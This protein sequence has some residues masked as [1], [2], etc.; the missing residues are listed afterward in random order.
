LVENFGILRHLTPHEFAECAADVATQPDGVSDVPENKMQ[1]LVARIELT[2]E[3]L[4]IRRSRESNRFLRAIRLMHRRS[5]RDELQISAVIDE[6]EGN[7][8][9]SNSTVFPRFLHHAI[10]RSHAPFMDQTRYLTDFPPAQR[11][12]AGTDSPQ[13]ADRDHAVAD[14]QL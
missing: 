6:V 10:E 12:E 5:S 7:S 2:V 3:L 1:R 13:H 8:G 11:R 4:R 14:A 9:Q